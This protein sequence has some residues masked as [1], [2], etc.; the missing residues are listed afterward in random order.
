LANIDYI[1][2][3]P[4]SIVLSPENEVLGK[5]KEMSARGMRPRPDLNTKEVAQ[6]LLV[7]YDHLIQILTILKDLRLVSFTD[8][9]ASYVRLTL[10]G[11]VVNRQK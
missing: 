8:T 9:R 6:E 11:S 10:L 3:T 1:L 5:I 4:K 2:K 7:S